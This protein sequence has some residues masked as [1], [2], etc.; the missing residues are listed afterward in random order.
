M[1]ESRLRFSGV[2]LYFDDLER[3]KE[4]YQELL[5]MEVADEE[6]GHH[7]KF[8]GGAGFV[9]LERKGCEPYPSRDRAVLFFEVGDLQATIDAIGRERFVKVTAGWAVLH[10]PEGHSVLL[11]E[12][13][14][15][16]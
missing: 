3:A 1:K 5:G 14:S 4:F 8:D 16:G 10:D 15:P 7:A 13:R 2:E 6:R 12:R 9:C 11:L